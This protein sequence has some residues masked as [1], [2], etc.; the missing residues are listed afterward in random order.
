MNFMPGE[1]RSCIGCHEP[2]RITPGLRP[3][4][5]VAMSQPVHAIGPQPGDSGPRTVH[6]ETDIQ[7]LFDK[8]CISCHGG[9]QPKADLDLTR[10]LTEKFSRSYETIL[11]KQLVSFLHGGFGSA[12]IMAEPPLTFGSHQSK[13]VTQILKDPCKAGLTR[14]EFIRIV[15]WIDANVPYYGTHQGKKDRTVAGRIEGK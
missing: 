14:E 12:N 13:L 9:Q 8:H 11:K 6:Y 3:G 10:E 1:K 5:A 15:T 2:R 4:M 7:P